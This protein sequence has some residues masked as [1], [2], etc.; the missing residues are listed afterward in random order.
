MEDS[1]IRGYSVPKGSIIIVNLWN[2]LHNADIYPEPFEFKPERH[3]STDD[4]KPAQR[5]PR[6]MCFG[7]GRRICPGLYLADA[8]LFLTIASS[9]LFFDIKKVVGKDGVEITPV[10]EQTS[11]IISYPKPFKCSITP[12]SAKAALLITD[13]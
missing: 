10:H 8:S 3:I 7:F 6:T 2:I 13:E 11:G 12:R 5:D 9:L 4:D 1:I